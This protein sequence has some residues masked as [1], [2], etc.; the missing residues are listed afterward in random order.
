MSELVWFMTWL[1]LKDFEEIKPT[2]GFR[3][4]CGNV[5]LPIHIVW[6]GA[7]KFEML[8]SFHNDRVVSRRVRQVLGGGNFAR[9]PMI[10]SLLF[11]KF[12]FTLFGLAQMCNCWSNVCMWVSC[13]PRGR[14]SVEVVSSTYLWVRQ[15]T[16][17]SSISSRNQSRPRGWMNWWNNWQRCSVI[18]NY[19]AQI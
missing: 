3:D 2:R 12:V 4:Y 15:S 14:S 19:A 18:D 5:G 10:I 17:R 8:Y 16:V 7:K 6:N 9:G 11:M 13:E 1:F